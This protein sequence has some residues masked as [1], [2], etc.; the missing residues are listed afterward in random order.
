MGVA[1]L[2]AFRDRVAFSEGPYAASPTYTNIT[3]DVR[4]GATFATGRQNR[5]GSYESTATRLAV[6][7]QDGRYTPFYNGS[8]YWPLDDASPYL[9]E[10]EYPKGSGNWFPFWGGVLADTNAGFEGAARGLGELAF[11]QRLAVPGLQVLPAFA[12][13]LIEATNPRGFWTFGDPADTDTAADIR[14]KTYPGL[15]IK[16]RGTQ[17]D[18]AFGVSDAP[19]PDAG[20]SRVALTPFDNNDGYLLEYENSTGSFNA[21]ES[22]AIM[23]CPGYVGGFWGANIIYY[24]T[25][26]FTSGIKLEI[27]PAGKLKAIVRDAFS[28]DLATVTSVATIA[29]GLEYAVGMTVTVSGVVSTLTLWIDGVSAGTAT[30]TTVFWSQT[31]GNVGGDAGLYQF[32]SGTIA[33]LAVWQ[34]VDATGARRALFTDSLTGFDTDTADVR[35]GQLASLAGIDSSWITTTGTF[36]R[37]IAAQATHGRTFIELLKELE[38]VE[39]GRIFADW[40]GRIGL[41]SSSAYYA[42]AQV[43][44]LSADTHFDLEGTFGVDPDGMVNDWRGSRTGGADQRYLA[45]QTIIGKRGQK[46]EDAGSALPL[47]T[48]DDV[49][50][51]GHWKVETTSTPSLRFPSVKVSLAK[52]GGDAALVT[53]MIALT[54]GDQVILEDLPLGSPATSFTGF[55]E[56]VE[57]AENGDDLTWTLILSTWQEIAE[58]DNLDS[59][60]Y[61][62]A[63]DYDAAVPYVDPFPLSLVANRFYDDPGSITASGSLTAAAS[64]VTVA[65]AAGSPPF[66]NDAA[67]IPFDISIEGERCTITAVSSPTSPQVLTL[68]RGVAPTTGVVHDSGVAVTVWPAAVFGV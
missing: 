37:L 63:V 26:G 44:T 4:V 6:D 2:V 8:P 50:Q 68:V 27:T 13:G 65:T 41:A 9:R 22:Y 7:N 19:G 62:A 21:H 35:L 66:T 36:T 18:I 30:Y 57:K 20:G 10:I 24:F 31:R 51:I 42:P 28:G 39:I 56:R 53:Q 23:T 40:S 16:N 54:E 45:T 32:F 58:F 47:T 14:G 38:E 25:D 17:G 59:I 12:A 52:I 34:D 46:A 67:D 61:D 43:V 5:N 11:Q 15:A 64:S 33:N 55:V 60:A 29:D 48:D 49:L 3:P 1:D